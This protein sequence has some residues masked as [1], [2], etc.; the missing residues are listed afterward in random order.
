MA[1]DLPPWLA[2]VGE[3]VCGEVAETVAKIKRISLQVPD[4][5]ALDATNFEH[6]EQGERSGMR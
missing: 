5:K 3:S 4:S 1:L 6:V 2:R